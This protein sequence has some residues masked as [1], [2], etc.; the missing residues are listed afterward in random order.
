MGNGGG[1]EGGRGALN[2]DCGRP[3][4]AHLRTESAGSSRGQGHCVAFLGQTIESQS[5]HSTQVYKWVQASCDGLASHPG[6]SRNIPINIRFM[7]Q[8]PGWVPA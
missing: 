2:K 7:R 1:G 4:C 3:Y 5:A 6:E 8:K